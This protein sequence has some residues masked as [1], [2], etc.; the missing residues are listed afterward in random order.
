MKYK[1]TFY[2][3]GVEGFDPEFYATKRE[4][5]KEAVGFLRAFLPMN[6]HR[7]YGNMQ[8]DNYAGIVDGSGGYEAFARVHTP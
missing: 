8:R 4:A 2:Q 7:Y 6:G 3:C 5:R 1:V